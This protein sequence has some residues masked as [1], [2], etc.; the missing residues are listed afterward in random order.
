MDC[1]RR[2]SGNGFGMR[3][4]SVAHCKRRRFH[5]DFSGCTS[6]CECD[7]AVAPA[8]LRLQFFDDVAQSHDLSLKL[9]HP[10]GEAGFRNEAGRRRVAR[11]LSVE[12]NSDLVAAVPLHLTAIGF[13]LVRNIKL[14]YVRQ[15]DGSGKYQPGSGGRKSRTRQSKLKRRLRK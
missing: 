10:F 12:S 11:L 15:C 14:D 1:Y 4:A 5:S 9:L 13:V 7:V 2:V 3:R 6:N 8:L